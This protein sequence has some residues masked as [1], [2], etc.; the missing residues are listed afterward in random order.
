MQ[1]TVALVKDPVDG[2]L[3]TLH[4]HVNNAKMWKND[5]LHRAKLE[6]IQDQIKFYGNY[7][8]LFFLSTYDRGSMLSARIKCECAELRDVVKR[9]N[10]MLTY[11]NGSPVLNQ[12][13]DLC[14][15]VQ[16][17]HIERI[18][19][20]VR[21]LVRREER[22][23]ERFRHEITDELA[24]QCYDVICKKEKLRQAYENMDRELNKRYHRSQMNAYC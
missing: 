16:K 4:W 12:T 9:H 11:H 24:L 8:L 19:R 23:E 2:S 18:G 3:K 1:Y 15:E 17:I 6:D 20:L 14:C 5:D 21:R 22:G 13:Y 10:D 7:K